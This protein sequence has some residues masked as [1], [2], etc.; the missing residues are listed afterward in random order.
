MKRGRKDQTTE[1]T[2]RSLSQILSR[3]YNAQVIFMAHFTKYQNYCSA[4]NCC[5]CYLGVC[6]FND[7][8]AKDF[9]I[10]FGLK[11]LI[12]VIINY[13]NHLRCWNVIEFFGLLNLVFCDVIKCLFLGGG[14][15]GGV[16]WYFN[17]ATFHNFTKEQLK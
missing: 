6:I 14:V 13:Y 9:L 17:V 10:S 4:Q 16:G 3:A 7:Q 2:D 1:F 12:I 11:G 8:Y 15:W 5:F